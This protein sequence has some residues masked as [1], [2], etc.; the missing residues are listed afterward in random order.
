MAQSGSPSP[1]S[2]AQSQC[3][4]VGVPAPAWALGPGA[5]PGADGYGKGVPN[6]VAGRAPQYRQLTGRAWQVLAEEVRLEQGTTQTQG[7]AA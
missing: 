5:S 4:R 6:P 2:T 1:S 3:E 7:G